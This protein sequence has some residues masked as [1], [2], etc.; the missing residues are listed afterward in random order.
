MDNVTKH[1]KVLQAIFI[2]LLVLSFICCLTCVVL[3]CTHSEYVAHAEDE[4]PTRNTSTYTFSNN[5]LV[6]GYFL[7]GHSL[8]LN[9]SV[10]QDGYWYISGDITLNPSSSGL[11]IVSNGSG[12]L[13]YCI[14]SSSLTSTTYTIA[15]AS[16]SGSY[17]SVQLCSYNFTASSTLTTH[18]VVASQVSRTTYTN[19]T[20]GSVSGVCGFGYYFSGSMSATF[21]FLKLEVGTLYTG[22]P[23]N[24]YF[25][26]GYDAGYNQGLIDGSGGGSSGYEDISSNGVVKDNLMDN[27][28]CHEWTYN[29]TA[30]ERLERSTRAIS[31]VYGTNSA[32]EWVCSLNNASLVDNVVTFQPVSRQS[33]I[34]WT[35][36]YPTNFPVG[37][38]TFTVGYSDL[39][40]DNVY[41]VFEFTNTNTRDEPLSL[42]YNLLETSSF[43]SISTNIT[44]TYDT[45]TIYID[46]GDASSES[47]TL[48]W[49]KFENNGAFSGYVPKSYTMYGYNEGYTL[50][51]STGYDEGYNVGLGDSVL[52]LNTYLLGFAGSTF[53]GVISQNPTTYYWSIPNYWTSDGY[54]YLYIQYNNLTIGSTITWEFP[55]LNYITYDDSNNAVSHDN[56]TVLYEFGYYDNLTTVPSPTAHN[57]RLSTNSSTYNF[58]IDRTGDTLVLYFPTNLSSSLASSMR[59]FGL[60][61]SGDEYNYSFTSSRVSADLQLAIDDSYNSGKRD[62]IVIGNAEGYSEGYSVGY[63]EALDNY[64]SASFTDLLGAVFDAPITAVIGKYEDGQRV[65]GLLNFD[66]LGVNLSGFMM[67][68]ISIGIVLFVLRVFMRGL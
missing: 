8:P 11:N 35:R 64:G 29:V 58:V 18:I 68:L 14:N 23:K 57:F 26:N 2:S 20:K 46:G 28:Y 25:P 15:S 45:V 3:F 4:E 24:D 47:I 7:D 16:V 31:N 38:Y 17:S 42:Y 50:G 36:R 34:S 66:I 51:H 30:S 56:V 6:S 55:F 53:T 22:Q 37:D 52:P 44:N 49:I 21:S 62:G 60:T 67:A 39:T 48:E 13:I 65:G 12:Y 59:S 19:I 9:N 41:I 54:G 5:N 63:N 43:G 33:W 32:D 40:S 10:M 1:I 27:N 61:W